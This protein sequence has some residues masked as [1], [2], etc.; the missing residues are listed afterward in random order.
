M[1]VMYVVHVVIERINDDVA[2][3]TAK[4]VPLYLLPSDFW[5][6]KAV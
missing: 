2:D 4:I 5:Q 3:Y 1:Y 6:Q